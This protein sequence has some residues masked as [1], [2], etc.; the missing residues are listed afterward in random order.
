MELE[1]EDQLLVEGIDEQQA[2]DLHEQEPI[3]KQQ[4]LIRDDEDAHLARYATFEEK[5][6]LPEN[7]SPMQHANLLRAL[8]KRNRDLK[9]ATPHFRD[10][11][12]SE[13]D[14]RILLEEA[15]EEYRAH[16]P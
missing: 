8:K 11:I 7:A 3:Q 10:S 5:Y 14:Y 4:V 13:Y 6:P 15:K 12:D 1:G 16:N 9:A 2:D